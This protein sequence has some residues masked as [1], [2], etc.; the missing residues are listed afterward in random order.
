[1]GR[2]LLRR[3]PAQARFPLAPDQPPG[4]RLFRNDLARGAPATLRFTDVTE[5]SGIAG[6]ALLVAA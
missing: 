2:Y 5:K 3:P 1:M 4:H 6:A